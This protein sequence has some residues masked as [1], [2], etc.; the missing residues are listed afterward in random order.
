MFSI[1]TRDQILALFRESLKTLEPARI[2]QLVRVLTYQ[3][4][5]RS[6]DF[7]QSHPP[8]NSILDDRAGGQVAIKMSAS[9][10]LEMFSGNVTY[11][12]QFQVQ[13]KLHN[14]ALKRRTDVA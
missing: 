6:F 13:I 7:Q 14:H 4:S 1:Y 11:M 12:C 10:A 8:G 5:G 3:D 2:A 9:V